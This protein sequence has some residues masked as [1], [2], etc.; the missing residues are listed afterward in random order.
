M[1]EKRSENSN[2]VQDMDFKNQILKKDTC[3]GYVQSTK[4]S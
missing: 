4:A 1:F 2:R 3:K